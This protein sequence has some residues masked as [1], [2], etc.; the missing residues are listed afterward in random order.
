MTMLVAD[1][2]LPP[3]RGAGTCCAAS[4]V[5]RCSPRAATGA[6]VGA[7]D[8]GAR[9]R[10]HR[11]VRAWPTRR[12]SRTATSSSRSSS[13]RRRSSTRTLR[14][15][16]G[17]LDEALDSRRS[18]ARRSVLPG[19]RRVPPPRHPRLPRRAH[20]GGRR[21]A[22]RGGRPR[23][24]RR[25]D[26]PAARACARGHARGGA[27]RRVR[28]PVP[29][30]RRGPDGRSSVAT[31]GTTR[32]PSRV[33]GVLEGTDGVS[34]VFLEHTPFYA[35]G[36]GQVGDT[37]TIVT[38]TGTAE[39]LD[40]VCAAPRRRR[41]PRAH[42]RRAAPRPGGRRDDRR[43]ASRGDPPQPH[44]HAPLARR[45]ARRARRPR[46]PAGLPRRARPASLRLLAPRRASRARSGSP[47][48]TW[49]TATS[50][51]TIPSRRR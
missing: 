28:L 15:G 29:P 8:P 34:E 39:V 46:P 47:S 32:R 31:R 37:G 4:C 30:R 48:S 9:R 36:G 13:A 38:E 25:R 18:S 51:A 21:G 40:T 26:A 14:T 49:S 23:G 17:L 45:A 19:E 24:L 12:S 1:G 44:R 43:R 3:T 33:V 10:G 50:S 35:E 20:R 6:R 41:A 16:L 7:D 11:H 27:R 42:P 5:A 22:R 2:V